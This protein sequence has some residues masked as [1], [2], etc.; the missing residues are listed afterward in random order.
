VEPNEIKGLP[1]RQYRGL[2]DTIVPLF[3]AMLGIVYHRSTSHDAGLDVLAIGALA[4]A[5][6]VAYFRVR[7]VLTRLNGRVEDKELSTIW[8]SVIFMAMSG[9][10]ACISALGFPRN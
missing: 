8:V 2:G 10:L 7:R 5:V 6:G 9:F 1:Y 4:A 3:G